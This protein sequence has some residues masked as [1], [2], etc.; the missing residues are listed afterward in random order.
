MND[1]KV[2]HKVD[3]KW[4][5]LGFEGNYYEAGQRSIGILVGVDSEGRPEFTLQYRAVGKGIEQSVIAK[6]ANVEA[7]I[8]WVVD[9]RMRYCPWC[10][11]DLEKWY[12]EVAP[13]LFRPDLKITY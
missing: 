6:T 11:C 1:Q 9:V 13:A 7:P 3:I 4:C 10:G 5:C 2:T 12:G 8:S